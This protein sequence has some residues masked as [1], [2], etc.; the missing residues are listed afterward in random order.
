MRDPNLLLSDASLPARRT[1]ILP[2]CREADAG[3]RR[4][5]EVRADSIRFR[6][7]LASLVSFL[8]FPFTCLYFDLWLLDT[9]IDVIVMATE[10]RPPLART[11]EIITLPLHSGRLSSWNKA[12]SREN[13]GVMVFRIKSKKIKHAFNLNH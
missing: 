13:I 1:N 6:P 10:L 9:N 8:P 3:F 4:R 7:I 12:C 5:A 11:Y 2:G